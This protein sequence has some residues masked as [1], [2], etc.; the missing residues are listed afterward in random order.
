[1]LNN[2]NILVTGGAGFIGSHLVELLIKN[3]ANV[4]VLDS[5]TYAGNIKNLSNAAQSDK[6][7]FVKGDICESKIVLDILKSH[8]IDYVFHL[9]AESH[10]DNSLS[11]PLNFINTNILGTYN[12]LMC[13]MNYWEGKNKP[14]NFKFIHI[15]TDEVFGQ[16]KEQEAPFTECSPYKPNSP[17]SASKASSD[18]LVRAWHQS[19]GFPSIITNASNNFGPRQHFEKFIP[20]VIR[21]ALTGKHIPIYGTGKNIRDWLF[22]NDFCKG[23]LLVAL[24]GKLGDN[25]CFGGN[26]EFTN[27]YLATKICNI[28]DVIHPKDVSYTKSLRLV[29][30]RKGHDFRYAVDFSKACNN[31]GWKVSDN[32]ENNLV[33]TIKYYFTEIIQAEEMVD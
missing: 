33:D 18:L 27:Y 3:N 4:V 21:T 13:C 6:F 12:M 31:L 10:V 19:Y 14:S 1:M 32:F 11:N 2:I 29:S 16:L 9:A 5:L 23:L 24:K 20:T 8:Q 30:D 28:L 7:V 15:S 26:K 17:Y 25:Y 22:V